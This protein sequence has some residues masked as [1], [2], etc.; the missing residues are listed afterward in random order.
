MNIDWNEHSKFGPPSRR[1]VPRAR[2]L[3]DARWAGLTQ[4]GER[5][6]LPHQY[7]VVRRRARSGARGRPR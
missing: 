1:R 2:S 5:S 3:R 6:V 7:F 4:A